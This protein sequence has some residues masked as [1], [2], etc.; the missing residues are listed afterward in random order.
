MTEELFRNNAYIDKCSAKIKKITDKG[1]ILDQTIFYPEGGGQPGDVGILKYNGQIFPVKNTVY[2]EKEIT[3]LIENTS[4]FNQDQEIKCEINWARRFKIMQVHTSLHLLCSLIRAPVTGGQISEDK[5]RLDFDLETKPDK[6][7]IFE[8]INKLIKQNHE[9]TISSITEE[10][11]S[12]NPTLVRTMAV[13]PPKG[14]GKIR[15]ILIGKDIDYQP[16]GG[17][18]VKNT[19][20]ISLIKKVKVENKGRMNKR[21]ILDFNN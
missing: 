13:Q 9:I 15:M 21:V 7:F 4:E 3:H 6:D 16:C 14:S 17:T 11:L 5:G 19:S 12:K 18:H 8:N 2:I 10:Y 1:I 20:D